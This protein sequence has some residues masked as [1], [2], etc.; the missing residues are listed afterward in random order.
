VQ[1][2]KKSNK[3]IIAMMNN[4]KSKRKRR[5]SSYTIYVTAVLIALL[6]GIPSCSNQE[7]NEE[8]FD[9]NSTGMD[10]DHTQVHQE[11]TLKINSAELRDSVQQN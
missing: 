9:N 5:L 4:R 1:K 8:N 7:A 2:E 10:R 6:A 11:D 3:L